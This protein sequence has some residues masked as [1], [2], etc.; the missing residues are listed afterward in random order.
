M[1][2]SVTGEDF[3]VGQDSIY[4]ATPEIDLEFLF[5]DTDEPVGSDKID[6]ATFTGPLHPIGILIAE[7][8]KQWLHLISLMHKPFQVNQ[9]IYVQG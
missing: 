2:K 4:L 6:L 3:V 8:G 1:G 9:H 5:S 7:D